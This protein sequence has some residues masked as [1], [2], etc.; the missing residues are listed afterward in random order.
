MADPEGNLVSQ[1]PAS[2]SK[3]QSKEQS[4]FQGLGRWSVM[5]RDRSGVC[6]DVGRCWM[7]AVDGV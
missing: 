6:L 4:G 5:V 3:E 7:V 1:V 2:Q